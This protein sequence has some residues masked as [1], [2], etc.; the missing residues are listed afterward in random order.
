M[1]AALAELLAEGGQGHCSP[2]WAGP[3]DTT[4]I[5]QTDDISDPNGLDATPAMMLGLYPTLLEAGRP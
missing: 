1:F 3:A 4:V 5:P 2:V